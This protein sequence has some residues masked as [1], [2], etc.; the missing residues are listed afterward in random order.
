[1]TVVGEEKERGREKG[2]GREKERSDV[3]HPYGCYIWI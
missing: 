1:M 2:R 3:P